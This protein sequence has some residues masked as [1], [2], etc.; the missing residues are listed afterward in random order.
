MNLFEKLLELFIKLFKDS[1]E[2]EKIPDPANFFKRFFPPPS[3]KTLPNPLWLKL[4]KQYLKKDKYTIF[5]RDGFEAL[6][7]KSYSESH[8]LL[9]KAKEIKPKNT[10]A[11]YGLAISR[12]YQNELKK[13]EYHVN[14][15]LENTYY[16]PEGHYLLGMIH[17]HRTEE[18][19]QL[20]DDAAYHFVSAF[21]TVALL[22]LKYN[23]QFEIDEIKKLLKKLYKQ[24]NYACFRYQYY[25]EKYQKQCKQGKLFLWYPDND[26]P[27]LNFGGLLLATESYKK[28]WRLK[29]GFR[30]EYGLLQ[31]YYWLS[32]YTSQISSQQSL[33]LANEYNNLDFHKRLTDKQ[34]AWLHLA[35]AF[36]YHNCNNFS[37]AKPLYEKAARLDETIIVT[38]N[39]NERQQAC[40]NKKKFEAML[41]PLPNYLFE[42]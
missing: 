11:N 15:A 6:E 24:P 21:E 25:S 37:K 23:T 30:A 18:G 17:L 10:R 12:Y 14:R 42:R 22:D 34:K 31:A 40:E 7:C 28:A 5:M 26:E 41:P 16:F 13:A 4:D 36:V 32:K 3:S 38:C 20:P 9:R 35:R 8:R 2:D 27:T 33:K 1:Y 29:K 19:D 39:L